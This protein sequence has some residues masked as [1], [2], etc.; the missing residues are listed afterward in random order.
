MSKT[1]I[2]PLISLG[3]QGHRSWNKERDTRPRDSCHRPKRWWWWPVQLCRVGLE[4]RTDIQNHGHI[5]RWSVVGELAKKRAQSRNLPS[6]RKN[7]DPKGHSNYLLP[8]VSRQTS[9]MRQLQ[10]LMERVVENYWMYQWLSGFAF[11]VNA[12]Q[13]VLIEYT[14]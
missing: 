6:N 1:S 2:Y 13:L 14:F 3:L 8:F 10:K 9:I 11:G 7:M 12:L 4:E 5:S